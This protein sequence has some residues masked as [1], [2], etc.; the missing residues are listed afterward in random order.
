VFR[1]KK[2]TYDL[3]QM[4]LVHRWCE[5]LL[6]CV[7]VCG[8]PLQVCK[9]GTLSAVESAFG[10]GAGVNSVRDATF[11]TCLHIAVIR[12]HAGL[13]GM[14][15]KT[16]A[17]TESLDGSGNTP[18]ICASSV[19]V[20]AEK[21]MMFAFSQASSSSRLREYLGRAQPL[22]QGVSPIEPIVLGWAGELFGRGA[23]VSRTN[24]S[25]SEFQFANSSLESQINRDQT[26]TW[27]RSEAV[28]ALSAFHQSVARALVESGADVDAQ[29]EKGTSA[30]HNA[31]YHGDAGLVAYLVNAG[32]SIDIEDDYGRT[33]LHLAVAAGHTN[34]AEILLAE[35]DS[36]SSASEAEDR[37][38]STPAG[39]GHVTQTSSSGISQE[40]E[41]D[42]SG[43]ASAQAGSGGWGDAPS[44]SV[45]DRCDID[46]YSADS[47]S[48][49]QFEEQ[50]LFLR[51][52]VLIRGALSDWPAMKHWTR[53]MLREKYGHIQ[54]TISGIPY[55][56][57]FGG[58]PGQRTT[59]GSFLDSA[60]GSANAAGEKNYLFEAYI[61]QKAPELL[62]D[63]VLP[64]YFQKSCS[65]LYYELFLGPARSGA[66]VHF[67]NDAWNA[68][69]FGKKLWFLYPPARSHRTNKH[70]EHLSHESEQSAMQCMQQA[71]DL[72]YVPLHWGHGTLNIQ[73]GVGIA[74][75]FSSEYTPPSS[76]INKKKKKK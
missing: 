59:I 26:V 10:G 4:L 14:L 32:A 53:P 70:P 35:A 16:G 72:L 38:G 65:M 71:G 73:D 61:E 43:Q 67:H 69:V 40:L 37:F 18:L 21:F 30:L 66:P 23:A 20:W 8:D 5:V 15:L 11:G 63:I 17:N 36:D 54:A 64:A 62:D 6:L 39:L 28:E 60:W 45:S 58:L 19:G 1:E 52:P 50:Y 75:E 44:S 41:I 76:D 46:Q 55:A 9:E 68:L 13:V 7:C 27:Y 74:A 51:K 57:D 34:V 3:L 2:T 22:S 47:F 33:P 49:K 12:R 42:A 48:A 31:A 29:N 56:K 25:V 24:L